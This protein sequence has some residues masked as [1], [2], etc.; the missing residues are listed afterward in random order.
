MAPDMRPVFFPVWNCFAI[1]NNCPNWGNWAF[2]CHER[3]HVHS[4]SRFQFFI[5]I[6]G[7]FG[8]WYTVQSGMSDNLFCP[9]EASFAAASPVPCPCPCPDQFCSAPVLTAVY[10]RQA[11]PH[12]PPAYNC[13]RMTPSNFKVINWLWARSLPP[14]V[15]GKK[16]GKS[17]RCRRLEKIRPFFG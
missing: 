10:L 3:V 4:V 13:L 8:R 5:R 14:G 1:L 9:Q 17:D 2:K 6:V 15:V 16:R 7:S 11:S 12:R